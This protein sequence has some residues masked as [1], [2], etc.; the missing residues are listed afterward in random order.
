VSYFPPSLFDVERGATKA[1]AKKHIEL[2]WAVEKLREEGILIIVSGMVVHN[3]RDMAFSGL[4]K[5]MPYTEIFDEALKEAVEGHGTA[6]ERD[7]AM[8]ELLP[9]PDAR[10]AHPTFEYLLPTHVGVGAA[11]TDKGERLW[12]LRMGTWVGRSSDLG[13][14]RRRKSKVS[15][16]ILDCIRS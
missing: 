10:K 8:V 6:E 3:L 16:R 4:G 9:R 13:V 15:H 14:L 12:T 11:G 7:N 1:D 5:V 2:G